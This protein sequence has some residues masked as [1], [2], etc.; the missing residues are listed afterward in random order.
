LLGQAGAPMPPWRLVK[1][2]RATFAQTPAQLARRPGPATAWENLVLAGDWTRTGLPATIEGAVLSGERAAAL[3]L[4]RARA[5]NSPADGV[6]SRPVPTPEA[7]NDTPT[8]R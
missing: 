6:S 7:T 3:A 2:R 8:D 5:S 4:R 1:E